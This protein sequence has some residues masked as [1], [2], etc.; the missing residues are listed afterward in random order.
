MTLPVFVITQFLTP[1]AFAI[2]PFGSHS[3]RQFLCSSWHGRS[4]RFPDP[5]CIPPVGLSQRIAPLNVGNLTLDVA[6][7]G[8]D[9]RSLPSPFWQSNELIEFYVNWARM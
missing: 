7:V 5:R 3:R 1:T 9:T 8:S 6:L 2:H 4:R